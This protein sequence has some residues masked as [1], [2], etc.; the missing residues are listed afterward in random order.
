M[1]N[2]PE[3]VKTKKAIKKICWANTAG[4]EES[5]IVILGIPDE[6]GSHSIW[7]GASKAP[8]R[9]RR[10]SN[11]RDIYYEKKLQCLALTTNG[12]QDTRVHDYG[13]IK[14]RQIPQAFDKILS[15]SKI[16]IAIGGDHS[17]TTPIL[18]AMAKKHGPVSLVYFDAHPDFVSHTRNYYG[19]V[20]TDSLDYID[21]KSSIQIGIRSPETEEIANIKKHSLKVITPFDVVEQG[22]MEISK[23]VLDTIKENVYISFDMDCLDPAY[24]PGVSVPVP[25]GIESRDAM[26]L[27]K[28]I[29]QRGMAG[30][31]IMEVCPKHDLN[32]QT[33]HLASRIIGEVVSSCKV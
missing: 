22:M 3:L 27:V 30:F 12:L 33:S 31:D 4:F 9:I 25:I 20:I 2:A 8:D 19:S 21:V 15:S 17:N 13:N 26:H 32:N 11:E 18:K 28:K 5:D 14:K 7:S 24:A 10:I 16:P 23:T 1:H 6:T 29:V